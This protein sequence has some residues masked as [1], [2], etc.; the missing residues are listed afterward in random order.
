MLKEDKAVADD[1]IRTN[2]TNFRDL[3]VRVSDCLGFDRDPLNGRAEGT[4]TPRRCTS[5]R[6][7]PKHG[8]KFDRC[9]R[10]HSG[11]KS[12]VQK[13]MAEKTRSSSLNL[14][15]A[16]PLRRNGPGEAFLP[17]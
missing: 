16:P 13:F 9:D 4:A 10:N 15:S 6:V 14:K 17:R 11:R 7:V 12:D 3:Y 8:L 2:S 1:P 5:L